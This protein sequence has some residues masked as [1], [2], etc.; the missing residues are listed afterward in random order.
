MEEAGGGGEDLSGSKVEGARSDELDGE[1]SAVELDG[2]VF[3][4]LA[5]EGGDA[6]VCLDEFIDCLSVDGLKLRALCG[7]F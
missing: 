2:V 5:E 4:A 1:K 7:M 6:A 3:G